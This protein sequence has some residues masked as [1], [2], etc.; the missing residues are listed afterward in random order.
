MEKHLCF[1][2]V[3]SVYK[4]DVVDLGG[5][6]GLFFFFFP[7]QIEGSMFL[8]LI[9]SVWTKVTLV[10]GIFKAE[11]VLVFLNFL[12]GWYWLSQLVPNLCTFEFVPGGWMVETLKYLMGPL[13]VLDGCKHWRLQRK[14]ILAL[15]WSMWYFF[16]PSNPPLSSPHAAE[17]MGGRTFAL[18]SLHTA[19]L[20][21]WAP[22]ILDGSIWSR[23]RTTADYRF[24]LPDSSL[25]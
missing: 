9:V 18:F 12:V 10:W 16:F 2:Y 14:F 20:Q 6:K 21:S 11:A 4:Q 19:R 8:H 3:I 17:S 15:V 7:P 22:K 5:L 24:K 23:G 13:V 1:P 25:I